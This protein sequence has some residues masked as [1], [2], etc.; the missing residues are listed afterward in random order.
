MEVD[1]L[2]KKGIGCSVGILQVEEVN[3]DSYR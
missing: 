3:G 1:Q 2:S